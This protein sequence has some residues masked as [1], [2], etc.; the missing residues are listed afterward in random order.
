MIR[1]DYVSYNYFKVKILLLRQLKAQPLLLRDC[2]EG[3]NPK[4]VERRR[5]T[6]VGDAMT[7]YRL[8]SNKT[9][10]SIEQ[11]CPTEDQCCHSEKMK[12]PRWANKKPKKIFLKLLVIYD[13]FSEKFDFFPKIPNFSPQKLSVIRQNF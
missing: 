11:S 12:N 7:Q 2:D 1:C 9:S 3:A 5:A 13:F 10:H 4:T 8:C 6:L